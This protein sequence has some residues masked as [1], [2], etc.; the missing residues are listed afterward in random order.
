MKT[1]KEKIRQVLENAI[2]LEDIFPDGATSDQLDRYDRFI[3]SCQDDIRVYKTWRDVPDGV[4]RLD[5]QKTAWKMMNACF[6]YGGIDHFYIRFYP[7]YLAEYKLLGGDEKTFMDC[8]K[9]QERALAKANIIRNVISD[10]E[11]DCYNGIVQKEGRVIG[12]TLAS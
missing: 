7:G 3:Y 5:K 11:G 1:D 10:S 6:A 12:L 2:S 4:K 8:M 9:V